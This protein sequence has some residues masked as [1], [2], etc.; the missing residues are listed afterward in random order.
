MVS[1]FNENW[2]LG[3]F[4]SE[5]LVGNDEIYIQGHFYEA[6][7]FKIAANKIFKLSMVSDFNENWYLG[8]YWS[9]ELVGND[10]TCIHM[11]EFWY[12][13]RLGTSV[14][15]S[16]HNKTYLLL[17]LLLLLFLFFFSEAKF[18]NQILRDWWSDLY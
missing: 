7:I 13:G 2:Y 16:K 8:V 9:E 11:P 10:E 14:F 18:S 15:A 5:E 1:D 4:W 17:L 6:T 3:V 12:G